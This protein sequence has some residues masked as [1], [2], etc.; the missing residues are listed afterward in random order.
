MIKITLFKI[1]TLK[2]AEWERRI[3]ITEVAEATGISRESLTRWRRGERNF[4]R[5]N[6]VD[7]LCEFFEIPDG[8]V[9]FIVY[10]RTEKTDEVFEDH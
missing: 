2:E 5:G 8:P 7:R 6:V 9:P 1:W 3:T 4:F 10:E